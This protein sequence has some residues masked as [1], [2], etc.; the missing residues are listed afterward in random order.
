MNQ[1]YNNE[2]NIRTNVC[3]IL[4]KV[5]NTDYISKQI[6]VINSQWLSEQGW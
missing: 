6:P 4:L 2:N 3:N 1:I 5:N